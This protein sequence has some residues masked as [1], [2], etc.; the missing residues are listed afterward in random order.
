MAEKDN[1][2]LSKEQ[3]MEIN[4]KDKMRGT[5][6]RKIPINPLDNFA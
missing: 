1:P 6:S 3:N 5:L 2:K 4:K